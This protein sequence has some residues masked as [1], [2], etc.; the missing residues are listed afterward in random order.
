MPARL[1]LLSTAT[2]V[3]ALALGLG[4]PAFA[5]GAGMQ[6][7]AA[8]DSDGDR[9]ISGEEHALWRL[10]VFTAMDADSS[11]AI[12]RQEYMATRMGPGAAAE[13]PGPRAQDRQDAKE[14][15]FS[16]MDDDGDGIVPKPRFVRFG[17]QIF[18][19]ADKNGDGLL[20]LDEFQDQRWAE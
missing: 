14:A 19:K 17:G 2:A 11:D 15:R 4:A 18:E 12:T 9:H 5:Q 16:R 1:R 6:N 10:S 13:K 7:F 8:I 3:A 20:T